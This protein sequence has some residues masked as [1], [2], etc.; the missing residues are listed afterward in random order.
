MYSVN[1]NVIEMTRFLFYNLVKS[2]G[3][4]AFRNCGKLAEFGITVTYDGDTVEW[5]GITKG[6]NWDNG[7]PTYEVIY[8]QDRGD[9]V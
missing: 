7:L 6:S 4:N 2:F 5:D 9:E 1:A 3:A 8:Y